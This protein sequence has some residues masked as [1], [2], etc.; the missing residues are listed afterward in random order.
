MSQKKQKKQ[1]SRTKPP[2]MK[3][4]EQMEEALAQAFTVNMQ[5]ANAITRLEAFVFGAVKYLRETSDFD[6]DRLSD[7]MVALEHH[8]TLAEYWDA[9]VPEGLGKE[10]LAK[11]MEEHLAEA[12]A[13]TEIGEDLTEFEVEIDDEDE[14]VEF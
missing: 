1:S 6:L 2:T 3:K 9:E 12:D 8:E 10:Q 5:L 7:Y 11:D 14:D 4:L 13:E